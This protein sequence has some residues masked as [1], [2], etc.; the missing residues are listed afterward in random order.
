[1]YSQIVSSAISPPRT[2]QCKNDENWA[3]P[4]TT[5]RA[6]KWRTVCDRGKYSAHFYRFTCVNLI[7]NPW[8]STESWGLHSGLAQLCKTRMFFRRISTTTCRAA[9]RRPGLDLET[10]R[11][12]FCN[13]CTFFKFHSCDLNRIYVNL[14]PKL[15]QYWM[16]VVML[17]LGFTTYYWYPE[18]QCSCSCYSNVNGQF[19]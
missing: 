6:K 11:E 8:T 1:M 12:R 5:C 14:Q 7:E 4:T 18:F 17:E 9:K 2:F 13:F 3:L 10:S 16:K 19:L 15:R